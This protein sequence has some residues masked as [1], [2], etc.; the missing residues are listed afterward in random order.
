[1]RFP[2]RLLALLLGTTAITGCSK[3]EVTD[4]NSSLDKNNVAGLRSAE[5]ARVTSAF[6]YAQYTNLPEP[7]TYV[8][9]RPYRYYSGGTSYRYPYALGSTQVTGGYNIYSFAPSISPGAPTVGTWSPV[10]GPEGGG[11]LKIAMT[12]NMY[13]QGS[14][15]ALTSGTSKYNV[16]INLA[17]NGWVKMNIR[18]SDFALGYAST[19]APP[20][21][22]LG[23]SGLGTGVGS[24]Q[25]VYCFNNGTSTQLASGIKALS[26]AV[27]GYGQLWITTAN[28]NIF[29]NTAPLNGGSFVQAPGSGQCISSDGTTVAMLGRN[30]L[31][32]GYE[33]YSRD[34]IAPLTQAWQLEP[35]EA[36]QIGSNS[37]DDYFTVNRLGELF[38]VAH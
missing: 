30:Y 19:G 18:A 24:G 16:W 10:V 14:I 38:L 9:G 27:D 32:N 13:Q 21:Y 33:V 36:T 6:T 3:T 35:G 5:V 20:I 7:M 25:N 2:Y 37:V 34:A 22:Y 1:M 31:T 12:V 26:L 11:A 29:V 23:T 28:G 17:P 4:L 15:Y 8:T